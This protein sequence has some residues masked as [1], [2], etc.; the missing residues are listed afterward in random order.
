MGIEIL[1]LIILFMP[2]LSILNSICTINRYKNNVYTKK[3]III[4]ICIMFLLILFAILYYLIA[5]NQF[6]VTINGRKYWPLYTLYAMHGELSVV[7]I[8]IIPIML[9]IFDIVLSLMFILK[10]KDLKISKKE[11][12]LVIIPFILNVLLVVPIAGLT[13]FAIKSME[14]PEFF[15]FLRIPLFAFSTVIII[16]TIS[17]YFQKLMAVLFYV[18]KNKRK[19]ENDCIS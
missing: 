13:I 10:K 19:R 17:Y 1:L 5:F 7:V 8:L 3:F 11:I 18:I 16:E 2:V 9:V 12:W 6:E 4:D 15:G 14:I